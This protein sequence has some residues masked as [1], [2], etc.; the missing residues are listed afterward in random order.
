MTICA[1]HPKTVIGGGE[2]GTSMCSR[3][4]SCKHAN[5]YRT[6]KE[7]SFFCNG[8]PKSFAELPAATQEAWYLPQGGEWIED[9]GTWPKTNVTRVTDVTADFIVT[10]NP[11]ELKV[12]NVTAIACANCGED[13]KPK[14]TDAKFCSSKCRV[15]NARKL[16]AEAAKEAN[17]T[18]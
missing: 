14:R 16:I 1:I 6:Y 2:F 3:C 9:D 13:F 18:N 17:D 10:D 8:C 7:A 15:A 12:V 4:A 5:V 11:D